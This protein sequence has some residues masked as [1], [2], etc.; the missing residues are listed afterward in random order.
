MFEKLLLAITITFSLSVFLQGRAPNQGDTEANY[1]EQAGKP[2][3]ILVKMGE[4]SNP[5]ISQISQLK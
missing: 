2:T 3:T 1:Q 5:D 4:N